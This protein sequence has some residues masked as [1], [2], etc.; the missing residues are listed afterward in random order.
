MKDFTTWNERKIGIHNQGKNKFYHIRDIWW[1]SL[2]VN[3]GYEQDG[4]DVDFQRP[5]LVLKGL[6]PNTCL[7]L[8]ITTSKQKHPLRVTMGA[9]TGRDSKVIISQM[10]VIDTKRFIN[11]IAVLDVE[12]FE[13]IRKAVKDFI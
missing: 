7:I 13:V 8:P 12:R 2:G 9:V 5:V 1:C 6:G 3:I 11:K 4:K 10:K